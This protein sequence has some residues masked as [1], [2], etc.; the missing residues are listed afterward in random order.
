MFRRKITGI[1]TRMN[2]VLL[3]VACTQTTEI[4]EP[5]GLCSKTE[6]DKLISHD[7]FV[8]NK[9]GGTQSTS[10]AFWEIDNYITIDSIEYVSMD[11]TLINKS[12]GDTLHDI[13]ITRFVFENTKLSDEPPILDPPALMPIQSIEAPWFCINISPNSVAL[14]ISVSMSSNYTAQKCTITLMVWAGNCHRY[15]YVEQEPGDGC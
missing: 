10:G 11:S 1:L 13:R 5:L 15:V 2:L 14:D 6:I 4:Y 7:T 8:F 3:V 9:D 12:T